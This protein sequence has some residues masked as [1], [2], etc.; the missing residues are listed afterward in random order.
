MDSELGVGN[1]HSFKSTLS[2]VAGSAG[3]AIDTGLYLEFDGRIDHDRLLAS[4]RLTA[5]RCPFLL[6]RRA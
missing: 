2:V 6:R 1:T 5:A 3:G 4:T